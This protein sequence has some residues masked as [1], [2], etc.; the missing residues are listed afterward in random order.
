MTNKTVS[1]QAAQAKVWK[2]EI[3]TIEKNLRKMTR[4]KVAEFNRSDR[5]CV[6]AE[7][8]ARAIRQKHLAYAQKLSRSYDRE[9]AQACR[10]IA[11]LKGRMGL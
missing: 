8:A 1:P 4:D 9:S 11:I 7:R 5:H 10:R 2:N 3:K 6:K